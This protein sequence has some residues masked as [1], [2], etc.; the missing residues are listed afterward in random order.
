[1][2]TWNSVVFLKTKDSWTDTDTVAHWD[3][4]QNIWSTSGEWD[5]CIKLNP[6]HS[7]PEQTEAFVSKLRDTNWVT[8]TETSWWKEVVNN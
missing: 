7:S 4:V 1:M 3:G 5:W 8:D 2:S 6:S